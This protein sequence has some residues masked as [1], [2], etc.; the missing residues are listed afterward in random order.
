MDTG[1]IERMV[2]FMNWSDFAVIGVIGIFAVIG[3]FKGFIMS[4][5]RLISFAIC[6]FLSIKLSPVLTR[7]LEKTVVFD[8]I[9]SVIVNNLEG[10]AKNAFSSPTAVT[11]GA[12][13]A[14]TVLGT[15][16][17]PDIFKN[18]LLHNLPSPAEL[19]DVNG[20]VNSI[21]D[22]LTVMII[23]ILSLVLLYFFLR[24]IFAALGMLLRKIADLPVFKQVNK[25]GGL[26]LGALEG[27]LVVFVLFAILMVF[28]SNPAF[29]PVFEGLKVSAFARVF[30]EN[31]FIINFLFPP[32]MA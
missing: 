19:V 7:I 31:N 17:M 14:E 24:V 2:V 1:R 32:I 27:F 3:L 29:A 23:S 26:I 6:V 30:Y 15:M 28:N 10:L 9:K 12:E 20:I 18:S 21:G 16:P 25:L 5:Y 4:V 13:G 22:G 8:T 11:T